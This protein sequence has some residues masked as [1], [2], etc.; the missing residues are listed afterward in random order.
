MI[1][2][3]TPSWQLEDERDGN[4]YPTPFLVHSGTG[5]AFGPA[6]F[7][8]CYPNWPF[9]TAAEAVRRLGKLGVRSNEERAFIEKFTGGEL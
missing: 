1:V 2:Q 9:Q 3:L 6:D 8:M 5:D 7:I 4:H